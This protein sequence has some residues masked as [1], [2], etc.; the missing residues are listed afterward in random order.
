MNITRSALI[1]FSPWS[2]DKSAMMLIAKNKSNCL[3]TIGGRK[4]S[5][6]TEI[7]CLI[8]EVLEETKGV[9]DY[10]N[11]PEFLSKAIPRKFKNCQYYFLE[12]SLQN[13]LER[14]KDFTKATSDRAVCN[15]LNSLEVMSIEDLAEDFIV[16]KSIPAHDEFTEMFLDIGFDTIANRRTTYFTHNIG[17]RVDLRVP[18]YTLPK[19]VSVSLFPKGLPII[20][21]VIIPNGTYITEQYY[22][23]NEKGSLFRSGFVLLE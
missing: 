2:A 8:R 18:I 5:G 21:G 7:L 6:E 14:Q 13:L 19:L 3:T 9:I 4:E 20:Y 22:F 15:E 1:L 12:T 16:N 10:R 17:A 23:R 11:Y